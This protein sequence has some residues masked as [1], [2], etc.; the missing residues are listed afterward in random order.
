MYGCMD[1]INN[2]NREEEGMRKGMEKKASQLIFLILIFAISVWS[3]TIHA[4]EFR[5][6]GDLTYADAANDAPPTN[7]LL[8]LEQRTS[9]FRLGQFSLHAREQLSDN[10]DAFTEIAIIPLEPGDA[11]TVIAIARLYVTYTINDILKIRAGKWHTPIGYWNSIYHHGTQLQTTIERPASLRFEFEGGILPIHSVGLWALG[12]L[13]TDSVA[14]DYGIQITNGDRLS[15]VVPGVNILNSNNVADN[16]IDKQVTL[17]LR[18]H[19]TALPALGIG[20]SGNFNK[21]ADSPV[22]TEVAQQIYAVDLEFINQKIELISEYFLFHDK[23]EIGSA[24][25]QKSAAFYAQLGYTIANRYIPYAR[26]ERISIRE[27]DPYFK[28]LPLVSLTLLDQQRALVG[29]RYNITPNSSLKGEVQ[30]INPTDPT[31]DSFYKYAVQ[32]AFAF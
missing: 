13:N 1:I 15:P 6:F 19:P 21:A 31:K 16:N 12:R 9:A 10:L 29:L 20:I 28:A 18:A 5:G 11:S 27:A 4:F 7:G 2:N 30:W 17:H 3:T 14:L 8:D 23:D 24:G 22:T 25:T 26:Y 32:W